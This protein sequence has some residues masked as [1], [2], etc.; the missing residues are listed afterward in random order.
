MNR[1]VL[2][3]VLIA[4]LVPTDF[5]TDAA[6][7]IYSVAGTRVILSSCNLADMGGGA[8][9]DK[10]DMHPGG[11]T[12]LDLTQGLT[13]LPFGGYIERISLALETT[14]GAMGSYYFDAEIN[15]VAIGAPG[16]VYSSAD[17]DHQDSMSYDPFEHT[18]V[19]G[20]S[21]NC[22]VDENLTA[23]DTDGQCC[24]ITVMITEGAE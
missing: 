10:W 9:D 8:G 12:S 19:S 22:N 13:H 18:F 15:A 23:A 4:S 2:L 14:T 11:A 7:S 3:A 16:N 24:N 5:P 17:T 1:T 20:D 6:P 21:L